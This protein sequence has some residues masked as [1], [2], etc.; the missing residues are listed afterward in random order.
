M[1]VVV[2]ISLCVLF[3]WHLTN[4]TIYAKLAYVQSKL[5]ERI[6]RAQETATATRSAACWRDTAWLGNLDRSAGDGDRTLPPGSRAAATKGGHHAV[7][8]RLLIIRYY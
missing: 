8:G 4:K 2:L 7:G 3:R 5:N 1:I 6:G